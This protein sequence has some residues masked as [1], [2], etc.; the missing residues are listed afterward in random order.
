MRVSASLS[1][2]LLG[3]PI[4]PLPNALSMILGVFLFV[5]LVLLSYPKTSVAGRPCGVQTAMPGWCRVPARGQLTFAG[6]YGN[7][8]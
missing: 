3:P 6:G 4:S 7:L 2:L 8:G 1:F 5:L